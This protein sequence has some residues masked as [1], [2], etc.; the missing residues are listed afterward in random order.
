[1]SPRILTAT[2]AA[3]VLCLTASLGVLPAVAAGS[4]TASSAVIVPGAVGRV[5]GTAA[6]YVDSTGA[7]HVAWISADQKHVEL[8][9]IP[10]GGSS[11]GA[12]SSLATDVAA[13]ETS[14]YIR[15]IKYLPAQNDSAFL[16]VGIDEL[17]NESGSET[18]LFRLGASTGVDAGSTC[19]CGSGDVI[20]EPDESGVDVVGLDRADEGFIDVGPSEQFEF[21]SLAGGADSSAIYFG[22]TNAEEIP[23]TGGELPVDL[24][25]LPQGQT[26]VFADDLIPYK[27]ISEDT[28]GM[29]VQPAN[30]GSFGPLQPLGI[31]GAIETDFSASA[32]S[33]VLNVETGHADKPLESPMEL[34]RF[35]GTSLQPVASLGVAW[36]LNANHSVWDEGLPPTYEDAQGDFYL[37]WVTAGGLDGCNDDPT[38]D[39][40]E[41]RE[42]QCLMYRRVGSDGQL[43]PKIALTSNVAL[44][45]KGVS[46]SANTPIAIGPIAVDAQ[47]AGWLLA[48]RTVN[49]EDQLYAM[50]LS[51]SA[52]PTAAPSVHGSSVSIPLDCAGGPSTTCNLQA[53]ITT[54][55]TAHSARTKRAKKHK[56]HTTVL[57][58]LTRKLTG[59][60]TTTLVLELNRAAKKLLRDKHRVKAQLQI[61]QTVGATT[62]PTTVLTQNLTLR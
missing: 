13:T 16:A 8:C 9:T 29:F 21:E 30:G 44:T 22:P 52:G 32:S 18:E 43:G 23:A 5:D 34:Y 3:T 26:A 41:Q 61:T 54:N 40:A 20:L 37:A 49:N 48:D 58:Q 57:A 62:T 14:A 1:V 55:T 33:Y 36:E 53:K 31:S 24:T 39:G 46:Y 42:N 35:R 7:A 56:S 25:K 27:L 28:V 50:P 51:S 12:Q 38:G 15:T 6:L 2:I 19:I 11:C 45:S 59:G 17:F 4:P 47:G 60:H 10:A